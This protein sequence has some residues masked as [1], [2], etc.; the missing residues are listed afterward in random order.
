MD[1]YYTIFEDL[2]E[3]RPAR[4]FVNVRQEEQISKFLD[5]TLISSLDFYESLSIKVEFNGVNTDRYQFAEFSQLVQKIDFPR[6][7]NIFGIN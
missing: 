6:Q 3:I 7:L 1:S 2:R 5:S 4:A